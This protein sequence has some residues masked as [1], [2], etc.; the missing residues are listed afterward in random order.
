MMQRKEMIGIEEAARQLGSTSLNT[1]MHIKRGLL[2]GI[3]ADGAWLVDRRS[4]EALLE[5]TADRKTGHVCTR[6]HACSG[7][8]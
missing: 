8:G 2:K 4:L 6:R 5:K 7:C 1:L 3:E